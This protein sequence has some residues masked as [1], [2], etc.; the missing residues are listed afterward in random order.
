MKIAIASDV[1]L[2]FGPLEIKNEKNADLLILAGDICVVRHFLR[3][4]G[5]GR[6]TKK[7]YNKFFETVSKEFPNV[8]YVIGNHEHYDYEF[9]KTLPTLRK[10]LERF[11]NINI[12]EKEVFKIEDI[13][14]IGGTLWTDM[15]GGDPLTGQIVNQSMNDF[16]CI[17]NR[18]R[19]FNTTD[20]INDHKL[21]KDFI[22]EQVSK[23]EEKFVVISH[24][25]PSKLSTH[26]RYNNEYYKNGGYSSNL[27]DIFLDH[28]NILLWVHGHTHNKFNYKLG[29][30]NIVANPRGYIGYEQLADS[31]ELIYIDV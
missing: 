18:D 28:N 20:A 30:T 16:Y 6:K 12:L 9:D 14:F 4:D 2:E 21:Y 25:A 15:N 23:K 19:T 17:K 1:H 3:N 8:I 11:N 22:L 31:W 24:H 5:K 29:E 27:Y 10:E 26:P 7:I 13:N